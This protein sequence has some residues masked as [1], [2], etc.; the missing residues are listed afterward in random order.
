MFGTDLGQLKKKLTCSLVADWCQSPPI[1]I[2][3][4]RPWERQTVNN[5]VDNTYEDMNEP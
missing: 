4:I 1:K 2:S 3:W 5:N